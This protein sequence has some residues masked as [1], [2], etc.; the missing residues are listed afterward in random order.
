MFW[1]LCNPPEPKWRALQ[2]AMAAAQMSQLTAVMV[3]E[4]DLP[5]VRGSVGRITA[6]MHGRC[7]VV[8]HAFAERYA[9]MTHLAM[10]M[11][12][13]S[14]A[15]R[16]FAWKRRLRVAGAMWNLR[17][18][19]ARTMVMVPVDA[20]AEATARGLVVVRGSLYRL[21][22]N[23]Y[24]AYANLRD[25]VL[26]DKSIAPEVRN[27][28]PSHV[29]NEVS[30]V[31][32]GLP[33]FASTGE[34]SSRLM[35]YYQTP[36]RLGDDIEDTLRT[37]HVDILETVELYTSEEVATGEAQTEAINKGFDGSGLAAMMKPKERIA[38]QLTYLQA[39]ADVDDQEL[40]EEIDDWVLLC[41][42]ASHLDS[43]LFES[44]EDLVNQVRAL[45]A[46]ENEEKA[47][48]KEA[49]T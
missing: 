19:V 36:S 1:M 35:R 6:A 21:T 22:C 24:R 11:E 17:A 33:S 3:P 7:S 41:D 4:R 34:Y 43:T 2:T 47:T 32:R 37:A 45:Q 31:F 8:S 29:T 15:R 9:A 14:E 10:I 16:K 18:E 28:F 27:R 49:V 5:V 20:T 23:P 46:Q 44:A 30:N 12:D 40:R 42:D 13:E 39:L 38:G 26:A 48:M 25:C